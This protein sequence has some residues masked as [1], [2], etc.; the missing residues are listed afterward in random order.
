VT[1]S[2]SSSD[3]QCRQRGLLAALD[4]AQAVVEF[5]LEGH[6]V[7]ANARFLDAMGYSLQDVLGQHHRIF[8][9]P[10]FAGSAEYVAFWSRLRA[11]QPDQG[12]YMRLDRHGRPVWLQASYSPVLGEDGRPVGVVKLATDVTEARRKELD[13]QAKI[14]A[15]DKVQ[16]TIEFSLDGRVLWAND[17]FL[18][19]FGYAL[20]D[21]RGQHH[22]LFCQPSYVRSPEY[23]AFWQRLA[24][25]EPDAGRY[26]RV[27]R[28]GRDVWIQASYTPVL[29][30]DGKPA[31]VVK[32]ATDITA[33]VQR[34]TETGGK[35]E[36]LSRSQA[37]IE[38]DLQGNVLAANANFLRALGYT[39]PEILGRHHAMF[40][41]PE[42]VRSQAYRDFW[43][44]LSEGKFQSGR[45]RR[46]GKHGI[47]VWIQATYNPILDTEG[48]PY[49]VVKFATDVT[50]QVERERE[51]SRKVDAIGA[52]LQDMTAAIGNVARTTERTSGLASQTQHAAGEGSQ[53]LQRSRDAVVDIQK[54]AT[55]VHE[56]ID[57]IG[58]I[59]SQTHLLAFNAAIE[60][61]RAGE[62]GVGFS[63]VADEVRKLADKSAQAAREIAR[64]ISHN[65]E[66]VGEGGR[67]SE[68][69]DA[70]FRRILLQ[71][72]NT[73]EAVG[74]IHQAMTRQSAATQAVS[75]L[76][77]ELQGRAAAV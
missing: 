23:Q 6:V 18:G 5:D 56:I 21:V 39:A 36:A 20:E 40:C 14:D 9:S 57:T 15:I 4:H 63:V 48:R 35:L 11:G 13:W 65:V 64:Q 71:V 27:A 46:L 38:F 58:E 53:L 42:Q 45:F 34:D 33:E 67:L 8:C 1:T 37:V 77:Q 75:Q 66:R 29:G 7:Q 69:V 61:A 3:V 52:V 26:R 68:E 12:V 30:V 24:R 74:E 25:G 19:T 41:E 62:H 51:V 49:K 44:D 16:A 10:E 50:A 22:R 60:A 28:D 17:N 43:A 55:A 32:Y 31:K 70:A 59:S 54:S 47:E 72:G 73:S 2:H 76:L